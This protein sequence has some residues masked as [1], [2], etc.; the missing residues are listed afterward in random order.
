MLRMCATLDRVS[1]NGLYEALALNK[2]LLEVAAARFATLT[3]G[4]DHPRIDTARDRLRASGV[5]LTRAG[6]G[7]SGWT[8]TWLGM[9]VLG[10]PT[11][12]VAAVTGQLIGM[13]A[14]WVITVTVAVVLALFWPANTLNNALADRVSRRRTTRPPS[15]LE[16]VTPADL[17][18]AAEIIM[19]LWVVRDRLA[20][21][22]KQWSAANRFGYVTLTAAG[23]DWLRRRD[24]HLFWVS[25][26]DR[27]LCQAIDSIEIWLEA[28]RRD[29]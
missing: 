10:V 19:M 27:C 6:G 23:F 24:R 20:V 21:V 2:Q 15:P 11:W 1:P 29:R 12:A 22:M 26:A 4:Q 14:G 28:R 16:I 5:A 18:P 8:R 25:C 9:V 13:P 7:I 3:D 17:D